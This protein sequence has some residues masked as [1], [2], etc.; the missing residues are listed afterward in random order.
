[1][2][3]IPDQEEESWTV[4]NL[5]SG[6]ILSVDRPLWELE[7]LLTDEVMAWLE[8]MIA[9]PLETISDVIDLWEDITVEEWEQLVDDVCND[10]DILFWS[11]LFFQQQL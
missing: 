4:L 5:D 2:P 3:D 1:M 7:A 6:D 11:F 8:E 10:P 9:T